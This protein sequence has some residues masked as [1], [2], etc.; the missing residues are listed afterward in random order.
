MTCRPCDRV[1]AG[2]AGFTLAELLVALALL[3]LLSAALLGSVRFGLIGWSHGTARADRLQDTMVVQELLR[4]LIG[5]AYPLFVEGGSKNGHVAFEG[6]RQSISF[7]APA[8]VALGGGG[9]LRFTLAL[10]RSGGKSDLVLTSRS[11]LADRGDS[12]KTARKVL[13]GDLH[14]VDISYFGSTRSDRTIGWHDSWRGEAAMPQL[15]RLRISFGSGH[16]RQWPELLIAPRI[17]VDEGCV[18][19][20][21]TKGCRGR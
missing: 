1:D 5:E 19:D 6:E 16:S 17:A 13:L 4:R 8:P 20:S 9:R 3:S 10:G 15:V 14:S 12:A 7:L 11:E 18:Y 21:L 2:Q